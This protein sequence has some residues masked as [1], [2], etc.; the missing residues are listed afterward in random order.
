MCKCLELSDIAITFISIILA[1]IVG[2]IA[3]AAVI[4][5]DKD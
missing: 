1:T 5:F 2:V 4:F 3:G